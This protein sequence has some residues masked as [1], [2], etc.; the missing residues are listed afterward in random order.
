MSAEDILNSHS[1]TVEFDNFVN[2]LVTNVHITLPRAREFN[3]QNKF[4]AIW[5]TG[6]SHSVI[7]KKAVKRI[8]IKPYAKK[9][10]VSVGNRSYENAYMVDIYLPNK[11]LI[12]SISITECRELN[13]HLDVLIGMDVITL[14]DFAITHA[15]KKT[16]FTFRIPSIEKIDFIRQQ[17]EAEIKGGLHE[18][19]F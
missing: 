16:V 7:T 6:A 17:R 12:E 3:E 13:R 10:V 14:G 2:A 15:D 5:D 9:Q 11:T 1:F 4:R 8:G 18:E 19:D